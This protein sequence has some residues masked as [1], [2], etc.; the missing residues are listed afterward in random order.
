MRTT[1]CQ[2]KAAV[3]SAWVKGSRKYKSRKH[4]HQKIMPH[5][6][7]HHADITQRHHAQSLIFPKA[8]IISNFNVPGRDGISHGTSLTTVSFSNWQKLRLQFVKNYYRFVE[9]KFY[10]GWDQT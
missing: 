8:S 5:S 1:G 6:K 3:P 7:R 10:G 4:E 2:A 9:N